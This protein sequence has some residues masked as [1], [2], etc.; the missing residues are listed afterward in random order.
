MKVPFL[1]AFAL[2]PT[3]RVGGAGVVVRVAPV[4]AGLGAVRAQDVRALEPLPSAPP[5]LAA[6]ASF[7]PP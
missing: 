6:A 1:K 5:T 3:T 2:R 4:A 7:P